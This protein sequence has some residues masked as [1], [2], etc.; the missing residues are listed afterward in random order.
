MTTVLIGY[1]PMQLTRRYLASSSCKFLPPFKNGYGC[2]ELERCYSSKALS[3]C[4]GS[5]YGVGIYERTIAI[6]NQSGS[7]TAAITT[8][9]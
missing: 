7:H 5:R 8:E 3:I 9:S 2:V 1:P 6:M 4:A